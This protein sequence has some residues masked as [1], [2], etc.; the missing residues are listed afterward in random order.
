M[1]ERPRRLP[2][3]H[4]VRHKVAPCTSLKST[5]HKGRPHIVRRLSKNFRQRIVEENSPK[6]IGIFGASQHSD[7]KPGGQRFV[8]K[9]LDLLLNVWTIDAIAKQYKFKIG[10]LS[11]GLKCLN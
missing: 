1:L 8:S 3:S 6:P 5:E 7:G 4:V 9:L 11:C 2:Q 10:V